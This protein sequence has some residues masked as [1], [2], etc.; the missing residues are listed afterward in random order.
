[1]RI[2]FP[3]TFWVKED[4]RRSLTKKWLRHLMRLR[5]AVTSMTVLPVGAMM[6]IDCDAPGI[7]ILESGVG[8]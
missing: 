5:G 7:E 8:I 1:M 6:E 2:C 3:D 4:S